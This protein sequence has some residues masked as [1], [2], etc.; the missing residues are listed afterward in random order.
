MIIYCFYD[1][2]TN[3]LFYIG[4]TSQSLTER[5]WGHLA[6]QKTR[7]NWLIYKK[8][9]QIGWENIDVC[10]L[11]DNLEVSIKELHWIERQY[12]D[13]LKPSCNKYK[14]V[15]NNDEKKEYN[16]KKS[17]QHYTNNIEKYKKRNSEY[18][19]KNKEKLKEYRH[20]KY[21]EKKNRT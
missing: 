21:L 13:E 16:K 2:Q 3:E 20:K 17:K 7:P 9:N 10:I 6:S 15:R 12:I 1:I 19:K 18:E 8:I 5:I 11:E 14:P 4:S